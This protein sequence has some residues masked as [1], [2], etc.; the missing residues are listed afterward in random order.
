[1][2]LDGY[3]AGPKGELD[4]FTEDLFRKGTGAA[5]IIRDMLSSVGAILL[6]RLTYQELGSYWP[7]ATDSDPF[8]TERMNSLPKIV[9]SKTLSNVEWGKWN[10]ARLVKGDPAEEVRLLKQE[11]GKDLV[12]FGSGQ[13]VSRLM[14]ESLVDEFSLFIQPVVLGQGKSEFKDLR[15]RYWLSLLEFKTLKQGALLLRYRPAQG[16]STI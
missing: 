9:F 7:N 2:S 16:P 13:L 3:L 4:W 12:I 1:M 5:D 10:T 14:T 11:P 15:E 8:I 6:G